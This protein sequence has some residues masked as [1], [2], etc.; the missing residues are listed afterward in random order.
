MDV[1]DKIADA[2]DNG[3]LDLDRDVR[4]AKGQAR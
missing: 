3:E 1:A 4:S 2:I